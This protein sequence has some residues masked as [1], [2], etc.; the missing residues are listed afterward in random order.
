MSAAGN[1]YGYQEFPTNRLECVIKEF[2]YIG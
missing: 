2:S 1:V